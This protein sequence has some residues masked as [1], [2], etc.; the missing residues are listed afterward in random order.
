MQTYSAG[1]L[2]KWATQQARLLERLGWHT[3]FYQQQYPHSVHL[4]IHKIPYPITQHLHTW[5][6]R[7]FL[8]SF[9]IPLGL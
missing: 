6:A 3:Y 8:L 2:G 9:L 4:S 1:E 5:L 7:G